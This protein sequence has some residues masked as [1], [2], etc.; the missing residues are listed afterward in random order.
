M[1]P[2]GY[3]TCAQKLT[4]CPELLNT[5]NRLSTHEVPYVLH[6]SLKVGNYSR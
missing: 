3:G 5:G 4:V 2:T 1:S 6:E